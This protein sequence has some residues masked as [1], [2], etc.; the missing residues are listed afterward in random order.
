MTNTEATPTAPRPSDHTTAPSEPWYFEPAGTPFVAATNRLPRPWLNVHYAQRDH[1]VYYSLVDHTG[2]GPVFVRAAAGHQTDLTGPDG[3]RTVYFRD[4]ESDLV[5]NIAGH[6]VPTPVSDFE[7][8][9]DPAFTR[10]RSRCAGFL[11]AQR[12]FVP[13][14][15]FHE[16]W[17]I[18]ITNEQP[19]A[20][21]LSL[22]PFASASLEGFPV[23]FRYGKQRMRSAF[24]HEDL[25]G[26]HAANRSP[27]APADIYASFLISSVRP[28]GSNGQPQ[29]LFTPPFSRARPDLGRHGR[30]AHTHGYEEICLC[31][32]LD[33]VLQPGETV[34]VDL[35]YGMAPEPASIAPVLEV[36]KRP[37]AVDERLAAVVAH[38]LDLRSAVRVRTGDMRVD[39]FINH[40]APKQIESY[41]MFKQAFR[42][43]LQADMS[44]CSINYDKALANL[45]D[46]LAH[47]YE[48]GH[49]PHSF[50]PIVP[51]HYSDKAAWILL[52]VPELV[53][54]SGDR[55]LLDRALPFLTADD[56]P[57]ETTAT[58]LEHLVRAMR[59][60]RD[61]VG[62]HG[63]NRMHYA[64]WLDG[65]D[66]LSRVGEGESVLTS[67]MFAAGLREVVD[68]ARA[69]QLADLHEE[70]LDTYRLVSARIQSAAWEG[71]RFLRGFS[72]NGLR[73]GSASNEEGRLFLNPQSW[74]VIS[75]V[76]D[77]AQ[78]PLLL[79]TVDAHLETPLGRRLY[80]PSYTRYQ[81][82]IG[83][84][85]AQPPDYAMNGVYNHACAFAIVAECLAGRGDQAWSLLS[86]I[87]PDSEANPVSV[88]RN[89]PFCLTNSF[90]LEEHYYGMAGEPWRTNTAAWV[91]RACVEFILGVRRDY[92]G[93]RIDPC[94]PSCLATASVTRRFRGAV[95]QVEI[96]NTAGRN[97]GTRRILV[98]GLPIE[99]SILPLAPSGAS[100]HVAVTI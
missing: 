37:E 83:C 22:H 23:I 6:P 2:S 9:Y 66:G 72:G 76:A 18:E 13:L 98:D 35:A 70:A 21:A 48:D 79:A 36:V 100:V 82:H 89:E 64:D 99:G 77:A 14:G 30:R 93:L 92:D 5:W 29:E 44:Y 80:H 60:L 81:H 73:V 58:V 51:L 87:L 4:P 71:D 17:T 97:R 47:Q 56:R 42:D 55:S 95:Y 94:L 26:M 45:L 11:C 61:D 32:H 65:L 74:A 24:Y 43:N 12:I 15:E 91:W 7:C 50:R 34:R 46:A 90:K 78:I 67:L 39:R 28:S 27:C 49:A 33:L 75:G 86:R 59:H 53:K 25:Q 19:R 40:W 10:L 38:H 96:D 85:S 88:S 8:I 68:M 62:V 69:L 16:I 57:T 3:F 52:A 31:L 20:R 63:M 84:I 41:L 54:E 1:A